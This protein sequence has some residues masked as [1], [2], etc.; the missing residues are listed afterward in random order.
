MQNG[1]T[2][3]WRIHWYCYERCHIRLTL[4]VLCRVN[5]QG[6]DGSATHGELCKKSLTDLTDSLKDMHCELA[7]PSTNSS[8]ITRSKISWLMS[9]IICINFAPL[10][11]IV[12]CL[13]FKPPCSNLSSL[14]SPVLVF[15]AS[16]FDDKTLKH[17]TPQLFHYETSMFQLFPAYNHPIPPSPTKNK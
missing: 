10:S 14:N 13:L 12:Q 11:S 8:S 17:S 9:M 3:K 6:F 15:Q 16:F 2:S 7:V 5:G 1:V 4:N